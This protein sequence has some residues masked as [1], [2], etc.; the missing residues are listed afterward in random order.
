MEKLLDKNIN[1]GFFFCYNQRVAD[2][3]KSKGI[4][5]VTVARDLNTDRIF[6]LY[7]KSPALQNALD[8]YKGRS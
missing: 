8:E 5:F 6:T 4:G 2:F 1:K 3:L 7:P